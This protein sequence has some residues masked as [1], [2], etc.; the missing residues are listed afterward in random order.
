M[1]S[2]PRGCQGVTPKRRPFGLLPSAPYR[3]CLIPV[4]AAWRN[5]HARWGLSTR[6]EP[7]RQRQHKGECTLHASRHFLSDQTTN[8]RVT[9]SARM[10]A[11]AI[12]S[13]ASSRGYQARSVS[14]PSHW[15]RQGQSMPSGSLAALAA[16]SNLRVRSASISKSAMVALRGLGS[17]DR[18][19][20]MR[21]VA[22]SYP[23]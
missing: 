8:L 3:V 18:L 15:P 17:R 21:L 6:T 7:Y 20:W 12:R 11:L 23:A 5:V 1:G 16:E 4:Y 14:A 9:L 22:E 2:V 10:C 19:S 13:G